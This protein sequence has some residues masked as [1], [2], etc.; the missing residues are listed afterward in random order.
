MDSMHDDY[1][2]ALSLESS[3][4]DPQEI[5]SLLSRAAAND[6]V[7]AIYALATLYLHGKYTELDIK[8][9]IEFLERSARKMHPGALFDLGVAYERGEYVER[10]YEVA[11]SCYIQAMSLGD[12]D[13]IYEVARCFYYGIGVNKNSNI[14]DSLMDVFEWKKDHSGK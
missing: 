11:F 6:C 9:A 7:D 3:G 4:G 10:N 1:I 2:A 13:S 14:H 12:L 5:I 8:K